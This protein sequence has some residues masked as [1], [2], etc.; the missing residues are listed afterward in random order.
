MVFP[1]SCF[2]SQL[3]YVATKNRLAICVVTPIAE[4]V[5]KHHDPRERDKL[6]LQARVWKTTAARGSYKMWMSSV[7]PLGN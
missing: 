5:Q 6:H 1:R 2:S 3:F 7:Y 4:D